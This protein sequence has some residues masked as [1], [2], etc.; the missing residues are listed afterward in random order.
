MSSENQKSSGEEPLIKSDDLSS[1][2]AFYEVNPG[3]KILTQFI[4]LSVIVDAN[5]ILA[6][7]IWLTKTRDN[8]K[9][10]T[11]LQEVIAAETL[12][13]VAPEW[14]EDEIQEN[15]PEISEELSIPKDKL[16]KVWGNYSELIEFK[17]EPQV[18]IDL[19]SNIQDPDDLPYLLLQ[20]D[21]GHH[22]YSEDSD[23][24]GMGANLIDSTV[25]MTLRDYSRYEAVELTIFTGS[26][27]VTGIGFGAIKM[28]WGGVKTF[29]G[30][31]VS[32][33]HWAKYLIVGLVL[34]A[35]VHPNTRNMI[36]TFVK[37][38]QKKASSGFKTLSEALEPILD[39]FSE[40]Q[41]K[42]DKKLSELLNK[43]PDIESKINTNE[44]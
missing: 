32:L 17:P 28:V 6:D 12:V 22:I 34:G 38:S 5:V 43:I 25:V 4:R 10:R 26:M 19:P 20:K 13:A 44:S 23:L 8:P 15:I 27:V 14:L 35:L 31:F 1:L 9:A 33:P 7:L 29:Y 3:L 36:S 37:D 30:A 24:A 40:T 16:L 42:S 39:Q 11:A 2:R 41:E 21:T 18:D